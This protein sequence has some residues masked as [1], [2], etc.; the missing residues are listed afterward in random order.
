Q[1][2]DGALR[3]TY[4]LVLAV[5]AIPPIPYLLVQGDAGPLAAAADWFRCLSPVSAVMEVLG[6]GGVGTHG[7]G[8]SGEAVT[9]YLFLA[10]VWSAVCAALTVARLIAV[11]LDRSRPAGVMT[12]D[13]S[14]GGRAARRVFFLVD[15]Q[16]RSGNMS[17]WVNPV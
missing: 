1:S 4:A 11:P 3:T 12:Q 2:I 14:R 8:T 10:G 5:C 16:R 7:I 15:P 9:R 17:R 13:R 6:H